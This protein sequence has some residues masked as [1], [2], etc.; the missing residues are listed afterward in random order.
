MYL[1]ILHEASLYETLF[2]I[3]AE[4]AE[5][6]RQDGCECGATLHR[7]NYPRKPRGAQVGPEYDRRL[8]FCCGRC[9]RRRT[10]PSVRFL[11]RKV[12]LGVVVSLLTALRCGATAVRVARLREAVGVDERTLRRWRQWWQVRCA[13]SRFWRA[14]RGRFVTPVHSHQLPA[15]LLERCGG[16]L[17]ARLVALLRFVVPLSTRTCPRGGAAG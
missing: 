4:L 2:W 12:Y 10:P 9:R 17:G 14:A 1:G 11:G 15:S 16:A 7:A 5:T 13:R 8:S 3:D 6:A